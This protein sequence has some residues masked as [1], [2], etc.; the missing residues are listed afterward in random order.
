MSRFEIDP[1]LPEAERAALARLAERLERER[2]LPAPGFR[3]ELGRRLS[4]RERP[5]AFAPR[6]SAARRWSAARAGARWRLAASGYAAAGLLCLAV[7]AAGLAGAGPFA[8]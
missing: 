8:A 7:A 6:G 5:T 2:P 1:T 3:G 4:A